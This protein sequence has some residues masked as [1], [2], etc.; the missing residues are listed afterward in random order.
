MR[1]EELEGDVSFWQRQVKQR[2]TKIAALIE[3]LTKKEERV[4]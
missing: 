1:I 3:A 2:E 4:D